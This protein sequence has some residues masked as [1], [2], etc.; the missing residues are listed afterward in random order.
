MAAIN[1]LLGS[2]APVQ[3]EAINPQNAA[4]AST[5]NPSQVNQ[6]NYQQ[7]VADA[8]NFATTSQQQAQQQADALTAQADLAHAQ[9]QHGGL[10]SKIGGGLQTLF[11]VGAM[12]NNP[13]INKGKQ[14]VANGGEIEEYL[15]K[16]K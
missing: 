10:M 5:Y 8:N 1:Q 13:I 4:T 12:A 9:S 15:D 14:L 11:P 16:R 2:K 6:F 3:G 7:A